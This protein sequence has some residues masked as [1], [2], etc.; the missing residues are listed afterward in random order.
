MG[1]ALHG[2]EGACAHRETQEADGRVS[3][4]IIRSSE[5]RKHDIC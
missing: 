3:G 2:D 4:S 5:T 1:G